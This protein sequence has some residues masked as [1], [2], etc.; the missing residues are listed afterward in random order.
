MKLVISQVKQSMQMEGCILDKTLLVLGA[1][2][3]QIPG[4]L[5]AKEMGV[6]TIALDG[7]E[8]ADGA[9]Y[10]NEFYKVSIK[11]FEQIEQFIKTYTTRKI[12]GVTAFGVD[13]ASII[14]K[15]ADLLEVNYTCSEQSATLSENKYL[16]KE[17]MLKHS[18]N[19]P[20]YQKIHSIEEMN[21]FTS[22]NNFPVILKPIDNSA[23]RGISFISSSEDIKNAFEEAFINTKQNY[24]LAESFLD[25]P[26]ISSESFIIDG[27]I[28]NIGFAD[29][30]YDD[31]EKFLPNIIENGGDLPSIYMRQKH[32]QQLTDYLQ[33]ISK[34]LKIKNGVIKG[35]LVIHN[36]ELYIIEF[37]LRLSGGNF[38]TIEI[39]YSTGVDFLKIAILL[40]LGLPIEKEDLEIK[41][42]KSLSLRYKFAEELTKGKI[43][44]ILKPLEKENIIYEN[45]HFK[46]GDTLVQKTAN[47]AS[48]LG[49]AIATG[50][51]R[52]EAIQNAQKYLDSVEIT[53]E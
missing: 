50:K 17:F 2:P 9:T 37:A 4:I 48:R 26:Q 10:A 13:I 1:G 12:D 33:T 20:H 7:N 8:N 14:A 52:E 40:H 24:L 53:L 25:G 45:F 29:R 30:N 27:E 22:A 21:H 46:V 3:D 15:T 42:N 23:A 28:Y 39:P 38:S 35:D 31:L 19:I 11:H 18:I 43:K 47:H 16:S 6:Y 51:G 34:E 41:S 32:K 36:D 49:F 5:K 44:E